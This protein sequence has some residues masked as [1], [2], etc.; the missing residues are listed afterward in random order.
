MWTEELPWMLAFFLVLL[1]VEFQFKYCVPCLRLSLKAAQAF[2]V[3]AV[4]RLWANRDL[5][6]DPEQWRELDKLRVMI[7]NKT[8]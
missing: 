3:V 2:A 8:V 6:L 1:G 5:L 4:I 7:L